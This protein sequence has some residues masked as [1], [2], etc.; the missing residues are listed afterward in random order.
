MIDFK[1][2]I[3]KPTEQD[4]NRCYSQAAGYALAFEEL[5]GKRAESL[6]IFHAIDG[7][8]KLLINRL[9]DQEEIEVKMQEFKD[10]IFEIDERLVFRII[11]FANLFVS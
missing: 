5:T 2:S 7:E 10:K 6:C 1:T 9:T 3:S 8:Q 11:F 4:I